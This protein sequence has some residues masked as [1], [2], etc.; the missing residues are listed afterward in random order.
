MKNL[1]KRKETRAAYFTAK[2]LCEGFLL[3]ARRLCAKLSGNDK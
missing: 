3:R 1:K 2:M